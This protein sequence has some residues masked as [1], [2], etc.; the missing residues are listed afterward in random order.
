MKKAARIIVMKGGPYRVTGGL[1]LA[2]RR[3]ALRGGEYCYEDG[4]ELPQREEYFLCRCGLSRRHPFCDGRHVQE[5]F[6]GQETAAPTPYLDRAQFLRGSKVSLLDDGRCALARFC[7]TRRGDTWEMVEECQDEEQRELA[8]SSASA[9]PAGR[10]TAVNNETGDLYEPELAPG[11]DVLQDPM[12]NCS[13]PL[14][15]KGGVP[16]QAADGTEYPVQN[17]VTLCRCGASRIK[18]FCDGAHMDGFSD[19]HEKG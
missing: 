1:P 11:V 19:G 15:V 5:G 2:E 13:G 3:I 12:A 8:I 14:Y 17:R 18:P 6:V 16:I 4:R 7:H 9:C 10:I